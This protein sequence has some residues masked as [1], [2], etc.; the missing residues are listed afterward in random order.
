MIGFNIKKM[1][2]YFYKKLI[3]TLLCSYFLNLCF[4]QVDNN[5]KRHELGIDVANALTFLKR[6]NQSYLINYGYF[7]TPKISFRAGLNFDVG[8]NESD[9]IYP[10]VRVGIQKSNKSESD[11]WNFYYGLDFSYMYSKANAQPKVQTRYGVGPV[12]GVEYFF[13]S[14]LSLA[15]EASLNYYYYN[16]KSLDTFDPIKVK[17]Y[18]RL[19]IGSVGMASIKYH[20]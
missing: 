3:A 17:N 7:F 15:T 18:Y 14:R 1:K 2:K 11:H 16:D 19:L 20:F 6:N 10:S 8:N 9:G 13:H 5:F 12:I 4:A